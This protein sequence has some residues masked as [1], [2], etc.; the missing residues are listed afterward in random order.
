MSMPEF[1]QLMAEGLNLDVEAY[2]GAGF[3]PGRFRSEDPSWSY[4]TIARAILAK[5]ESALDMGTGEGGVLASLASAQADS[6]VRG[7][8]ANGPSCVVEIEASRRPPRSRTRQ[9]RQ[10]G[11]TG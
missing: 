4:A 6:R 2:W 11:R 10:C 3:L 8:V 5:A 1:D 9:Q 7:V